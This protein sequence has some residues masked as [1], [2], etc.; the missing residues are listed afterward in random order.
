MDGNSCLPLGLASQQTDGLGFLDR[1]TVANIL[2]DA[3][4]VCVVFS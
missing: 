2:Y 3:N 4:M 1:R